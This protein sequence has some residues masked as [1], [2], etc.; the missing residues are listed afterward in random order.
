[1]VGSDGWMVGCC[2]YVGAV[3][4]KYEGEYVGAVEGKYDGEYVGAVEGEYDGE[5]VGSVEGEYVGAYMVSVVDGNA[6]GS[7]YVTD[8]FI[9]SSINIQEIKKSIKS[10]STNGSVKI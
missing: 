1:M 7:K 9:K 6:V 4:G 3:E 5:Y 10:R 2:E 8:L